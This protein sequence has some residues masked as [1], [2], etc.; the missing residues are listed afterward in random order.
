MGYVS[1]LM[2]IQSTFE[3]AGIGFLDKDTGCRIGVELA[4]QK[5]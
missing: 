4:Q 3:Q 2:H 1:T 5:T